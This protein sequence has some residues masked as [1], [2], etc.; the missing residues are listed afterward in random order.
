[1]GI[2]KLM[3]RHSAAKERIKFGLAMLLCDYFC[4]SPRHCGR[5]ARKRASGLCR[6]G[7]INNSAVFFLIIE[8]ITLFLHA[9]LRCG[10]KYKSN[11]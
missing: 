10:I 9:H 6:W 1:M 8:R 4:F 3:R 2:E 7:R 5:F 11:K